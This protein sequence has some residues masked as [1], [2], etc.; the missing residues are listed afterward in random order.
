MRLPGIFHLAD[1]FASDLQF[2]YLLAYQSDKG[3]INIRSYSM[4][5]EIHMRSC[6][7]YDAGG[8][9]LTN[10]PK[11]NFIYGPN[12]SGKSTISNFLQNPNNPFYASSSIVWD[13]DMH[14]DVMVYNRRF[15]ENNFRINS[16]IAGVFTLGSATIEDIQK[17]DELK[18]KREL[19]LTS[20][21]KES[22]AYQR[23]IAERTEKR[24][25]FRDTVW[26]VI[27][28]GY[29]KQ[30]KEAFSGLRNNKDKFRDKVVERFQ[31]NHSSPFILEELL[32]RSQTLYATK[33]EACSVFALPTEPMLQEI[34]AIEADSI[35]QT[36][37]AGN[38]DI[39][40]GKL[41]QTLH[42]S[43]W[44]NHGRQYMRE[45]SKCP[46]CQRDTIDATFRMQIESFFSGEYEHRL[47][48]VDQLYQSYSK[49]ASQTVSTFRSNLDNNYGCKI[50]KL[51]VE[52][53]RTQLTLLDQAYAGN[54]TAIATKHSE[55]GKRIELKQT[56]ALIASL[57]Q[58]LSSANLDIQKHNQMVLHLSDERKA[59]TNDI[60][61]F[62]MDENEAL[63]QSYLNDEEI[64]NKKKNGLER[65]LTSSKKELDQL[66][67]QIAEAGKNITSVQPTVDEINR[68]LLAYG[69]NNFRIESSPHN[70]NMYQIQRPDGSLAA[71]TLSEGEETFIT[72]LYFMQLAKGSP[73]ASAV[74]NKR[75]L[76][77]DDP[78]C[79]LDSTILYV[80]SAMVKS[81]IKNVKEGIT[82]VE[83][84]FILTHN[85][86]FHK[87]A[88]FVNG[89]TNPEASVNFWVLRKNDTCT[90][91][92]PHG[93]N[94][95]IST[96]YELLWQELRSDHPASIITTQNTM[97]RII[98]NY[99]GMLGGAKEDFVVSKFQS[100]EEQM[101]CRSLFHWINDGSHTIPDDLYFDNQSTSIEKYKDIFKRIFEVTNHQA[102]YEMMMGISSNP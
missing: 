50:G 52:V 87:E 15:R 14:P 18:A 96:S 39:P 32:A 36:V 80:V 19:R 63:I 41:I 90:S 59:L 57:H 69:F 61:D 78:I 65:K 29:D 54:L 55:P 95:P 23:F 60:W 74:S 94:N 1:N 82:S 85:V 24:S 47:A 70:P 45:D 100:V 77:I 101:I 88:S 99:F 30:F 10:C 62:L 53:Y 48:Q 66:K 21:R 89:R 92:T 91:I 11:V 75:I 25:E 98:E 17:L 81:L 79:S 76:V 102:H 9:S 84:V 56:A 46:F 26:N 27:L 42:N 38:Q 33:P 31:Q 6:A 13:G 67:L 86:F 16:D 44:V 2:P 72:F 68:S 8:I 7:T 51:N 97:R 20:F 49:Y 3:K 28:K 40:I 35:F 12:G 37:I 64:F 43:D 22:D 71:D 83:Q 4:I 5:K 34:A 73:N 58:M 93:I